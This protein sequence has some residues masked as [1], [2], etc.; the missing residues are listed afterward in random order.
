MALR[1]HT[2]RKQLK[3]GPLEHHRFLV[4]SSAFFFDSRVERVPSGFERGRDES[5]ETGRWTFFFFSETRARCAKKRQVF[6]CRKFFGSPCRW[7]EYQRCLEHMSFHE[8]RRDFLRVQRLP[9]QFKFS[10]YLESC[11]QHVCLQFTEIRDQVWV[12]AI[13]VLAL[14]LF[15]AALVHDDLSTATTLNLLSCVAATLAVTVFIK[16]EWIYWYVLH[17]EFLHR[18][19]RA[20]SN[21]RPARA[22]F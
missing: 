22:R 8:I 1:L 12:L 2:L 17:S 4:F 3:I 9:H 7:V 6:S 21:N 16:I 13:I 20:R 15:V 18:A 14:H 5:R 10:M 19:T 11:M